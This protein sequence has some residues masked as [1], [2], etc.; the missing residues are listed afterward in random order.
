MSELLSGWGL[1][2]IE[3]AQLVASGCACCNSSE[4]IVDSYGCFF[5]CYMFC[6]VFLPLCSLKGVSIHMELVLSFI[7]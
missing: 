4:R 7:Q 2:K 5:T 3:G 6:W 1:K